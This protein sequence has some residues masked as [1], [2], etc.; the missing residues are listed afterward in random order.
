LFG[1]EKHPG[2]QIIRGDPFTHA[3]R[4][5]GRF[6]RSSALMVDQSRRGDLRAVPESRLALFSAQRRDEDDPDEYSCRSKCLGCEGAVKKR[7][8]RLRLTGFCIVVSALG[9][10]VEPSMKPSCRGAFGDGETERGIF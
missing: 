10:P 1:Q 9:I 6:S 5:Q 7:A 2:R 8:A 4:E 3:G